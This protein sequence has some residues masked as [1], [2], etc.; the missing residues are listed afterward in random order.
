MVT[1]RQREIVRATVPALTEHGE[2]I[3]RTFHADMLAAHP[4][5]YNLFNS[6]N[7]RDGGQVR[8]L[9]TSRGTRQHGC[10]RWANSSL[11]LGLAPLLPPSQQQQAEH[12][13][14]RGPAGEYFKRR[15]PS[16]HV[17]VPPLQPDPCAA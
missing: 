16:Y 15:H 12:D 11:G 7:Q 9:A 6:A 3:T 2:T 10:C 5:L 8:S 4:E 17:I 1:T 13:G 14:K